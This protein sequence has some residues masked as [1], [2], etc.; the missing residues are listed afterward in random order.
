MLVDAICR[1]A[2]GQIALEQVENEPP[3]AG[4]L[5]V[6]VTMSAVSPGTERALI[7]GAENTGT[8]QAGGLGYAAVGTVEAIGSQVDA[9][10]FAPGTRVACFTL[11]HREVG[12]VAANFS[13]PAP[14]EIDDRYAALTSIGQ[15]ALQAVRKARIE[16]GEAVAVFGLGPIG[17]TALAY[18][19]LTGAHP[20]IAIDRAPNRLEIAREMGADVLV[21]TSDEGWQRQI[22]EQ[23]GGR[24]PA[25]VIESTGFPEPVSLSFAIAAKF[26]RVVL[27]GST[28]AR[29]DFDP[30]QEIHRPGLT[31]IGAHVLSV[32]NTESH[33][34]YW[35]WQDDADAYLRLVGSGRLNLEPIME[36]AIGYHAME[37]VY[38]RILEW[39][40][41]IMVP[42]LDWSA[43]S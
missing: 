39:D 33:P 25:I 7:L 30:Y 4:E 37:S 27:L 24:G 19:R 40:P 31:V 36:P 35:T 5:T 16:I 12:N 38:A 14:A 29:A 42:F 28:R 18:A 8:M 34:G 21:N 10:R 43:G 17:L 41:G 23:T 22:A 20:V 9:E 26:A 3:E 11:A 1:K 13:I 2:K 6:R 32:P 15:I